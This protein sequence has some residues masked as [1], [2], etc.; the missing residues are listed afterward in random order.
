MFQ[1]EARFGRVSRPRSCWAPA[2]QR[3]EV[4]SQIIREYVYVYGAV[5][6]LD[7]HHDSLILPY[8]N[9]E[10]MNIFLEEV[11]RR[12]PEEQILMF[13]DQAAWHKSKE[14]K[15]PSNIE[16]AFVPPYSPELNP[17]E[18]I[19]DELREK[20]FANRL[21]STM[22]AVIEQAIIGLRHIES[23]AER[24]KTLTAREWILNPL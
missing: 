13:T 19:W 9:T 1:D 18:Q 16:L 2:L 5:S 12:H 20:F 24:V 15:T 10:S 21:F 11:S 14:L 7:G 6:P 22:K 17:Q 4:S 8:S 3:P 23:F